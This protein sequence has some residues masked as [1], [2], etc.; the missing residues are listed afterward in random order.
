MDPTG[1]HMSLASLGKESHKYLEKSVSSQV[2]TLPAEAVATE[3]DKLIQ[4]ESV[5]T[6]RVRN[7]ACFF[8][9]LD[10]CPHIFHC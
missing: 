7:V 9:S 1:S 10:F 2:Q 4:V 3:K 5:Q 8:S 6:G